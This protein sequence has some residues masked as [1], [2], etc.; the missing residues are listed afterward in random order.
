VPSGS[1]HCRR[2]ENFE[3]QMAVQRL[4]IQRAGM[5]LLI[6]TLAL[7][8]EWGARAQ[9]PSCKLYK[10]QANSAN[11][12]KEPRVDAVFI[13][14][15]DK[16][17][18]VCVSRE[19]KSAGLD[20]AY[21]PYKLPT[22]GEHAPV[23]G[24]VATAQLQQISAGETG[25]SSV[26][27]PAVAG[28]PAKAPSQPSSRNATP[29]HNEPSDS[30]SNSRTTPAADP[31]PSTRSPGTAGSQDDILRY[32]R[33]IPF[34][35]YPVMGKSI[36]E[37]AKG[38]PLFPPIEGLDENEWK[39]TCSSCHQWTRDSLCMQ[40]NSYAKNPRSTLRHPHPYG[41]VYKSALMQWAKTGCK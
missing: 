23:E 32:S 18:I 35:A 25:A 14:L 30:K 15:L 34:G 1:L 8:G 26:E 16:G 22:S 9:A 6:G 19:Q 40:A 33:P 41:G 37:L 27:A 17:E 4:T 11:V 12:S 2:N 24:W 39:K 36:E 29:R 7:L 21:I 3:S 20:W 28:S 13:D 38:V 10:V 5:C 31:R